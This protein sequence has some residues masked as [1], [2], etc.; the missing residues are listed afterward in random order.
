MIN[1]VHTCV[2]H[3]DFFFIACIKDKS[4]FKKI[5][6]LIYGRVKLFIYLKTHKFNK[7]LELINS[8]L[9]KIKS[10]NV[11]MGYWAVWKFENF[12]CYTTYMDA[13]K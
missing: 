11:L 10:H 12:E 7:Q 6:S 3:F 9:N 1:I 13:N 2:H 5:T 4:T 8:S